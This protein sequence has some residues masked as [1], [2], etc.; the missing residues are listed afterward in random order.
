[1]MYSCQIFLIFLTFYWWSIAYK[2]LYFI[3][4]S[5]MIGAEKNKIV[6]HSSLY[7]L[8]YDILLD[9]VSWIFFLKV[10]FHLGHYLCLP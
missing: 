8:P 2:M 10:N 5:H 1:M 7:A 9:M 6:L 3:I 4:F